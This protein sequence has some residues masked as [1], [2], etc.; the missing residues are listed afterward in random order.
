MENPLMRK[1]HEI[2]AELAEVSAEL[3][4]LAQLETA[5]LEE[6]QAADVKVEELKAELERS[7][8]L[9]DLKVRILAEAEEAKAAAQQP[10]VV[11]EA[12]QPSVEEE[13][14]M[15]IPAVVATSRSKY[16]ASAEDAYI[17][18]QAIRAM[19]GNRQAQSFM[20]DM[21]TND[22][23]GS[24]N[25]IPAPLSNALI[26]LLEEYGVARQKCKRIV[27]SQNTWDVPKLNGHVTINYTGEAQSIAASDVSFEQVNLVA[28]KMTALTKL[29]SEV[30]EDSIISMMDTVVQSMAYQLAIEEDKNL[31]LGVA[32]HQRC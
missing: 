1:P 9:E 31:F 11:A 26:N 3:Q 27:M 2:K 25:T 4:A 5:S 12:I 21:A 32:G 7:Q 15:K 22:S 23:N 13:P 30:T 8:E 24:D 20:N 6:V 10:S 29:S 17:S 14:Q 18:G 16:F 19:A 28:K